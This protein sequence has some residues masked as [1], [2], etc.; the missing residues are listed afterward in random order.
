MA[1][2]C[3][4]CDAICA[5]SGDTSS[6]IVDRAGIMDCDHCADAALDALVDEDPEAFDDGDLDE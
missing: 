3:P 4:N 2:L 1:H 5:C 6:I